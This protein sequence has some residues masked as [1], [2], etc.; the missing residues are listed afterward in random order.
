MHRPIFL[1]LIGFLFLLNSCKPSTEKNKNPEV[2]VNDTLQVVQEETQKK[3]AQNGNF[4]EAF[5]DFLLTI[6]NEDAAAFSQFIDLER[7]L[8]II[9]NPGAMPKMTQVKNIQEFKRE[10]QDRSFFTIRE[11]LDKCHMK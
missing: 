1:F 4:E 10:Y 3:E 11:K 9:E 7:G 2:I 6:K 8:W 5:Q